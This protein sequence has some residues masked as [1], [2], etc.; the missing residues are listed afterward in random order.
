MQE[1]TCLKHLDSRLSN[2]RVSTVKN[3]FVNLQKNVA[4]GQIGE[5][6]ST[7]LSLKR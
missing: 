4:K 6:A 5:Y 3:L 7:T 2:R 1:V